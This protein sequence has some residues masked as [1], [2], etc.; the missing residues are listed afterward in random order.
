MLETSLFKELY[1]QKVKTD[2]IITKILNSKCM[3]RKQHTTQV[4]IPKNGI[5]E[6]FRNRYV[7][8]LDV[9]QSTSF[10]CNNISLDLGFDIDPYNHSYIIGLLHDIGH[11]PFAHLGEKLLNKTFKEMGLQEGFDSNN[12]NYIVILKEY[13]YLMYYKQILAGL[14]KYPDKLYSELQF[15]KEIT[16]EEIKKEK[17]YFQSNDLDTKHKN[18]TFLCEIMDEVDRNC[19]ISMDL[20]DAITLN[21]INPEIVLSLEKNFQNDKTC[22]KFFKDL[23]IYIGKPTQRKLFDLFLNFK[24][25]L[26]KNLKFIDGNIEHKNKILLDLRERLYN[27]IEK[28]YFFLNKQ[29]L[30]QFDEHIIKY[31]KVLKHCINNNIFFGTTYKKLILNATS[32]QEKLKYFRNMFADMN[33]TFIVNDF[34]KFKLKSVVTNEENNEFK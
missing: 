18:K 9:A 24:N 34:K 25:S 17:K 16:I 10:V 22:L 32:K 20:C 8:S 28:P 31:E 33:D 29:V 27:E 3:L 13:P 19:Y 21:Y 11:P 26:N 23:K 6:N 12:N 14:C 15:I 5:S 2:E 7:H 1:K 30:Q 4:V